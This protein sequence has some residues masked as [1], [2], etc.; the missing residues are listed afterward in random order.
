M[1]KVLNTRKFR[2]RHG[3]RGIAAVTLAVSMAAFGCTTNQNRA[4]GEP[5]MNTTPAGTAAPASTTTP[6]TSSTPT[7]PPPMVSAAVDASVDAIAVLKANEGFQGKVLGTAVAG[8]HP[9]GGGA[10]LQQVSGQFISPSVLA[11]PQNTVNSSLSSAPVPGIQS[12][13]AGDGAVL[14]VPSGTGL[15]AAVTTAPTVAPATTAGAGI[16]AP[17]TT[18]TVTS[19]ATNTVTTGIS[20]STQPTTS[21]GS[22]NVVVGTGLVSAPAASGSVLA[23]PTT[24]IDTGTA[25][26][27]ITPRANE[28]TVA[29]ATSVS[30]PARTS[31]ATT[32]ATT[33]VGVRSGL[34]APAAT[35]P[36]GNVRVETIDGRVTVTNSTTRP[37]LMRRITNALR[38]TRPATTTTRTQETTTTTT[39][40]P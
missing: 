10:S 15:S 38:I 39:P 11:N 25:A 13:A 21:V 18:N 14:A 20:G 37:T 5:T 1:R 22:G 3:L 34:N 31:G 17:A 35:T 23:T 30:A 7:T 27:V 6:G 24:G 19:P 2:A 28:T 16:V 32:T 8:N 40:N 29:P 33:Q 12:G 4:S 26:T 36:S 9:Q